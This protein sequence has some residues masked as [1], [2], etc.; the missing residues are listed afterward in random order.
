MAKQKPH[1]CIG[2]PLDGQK[3]TSDEVSDFNF[4]LYNATRNLQSYY[5]QYNSSGRDSKSESC[6]WIWYELVKLSK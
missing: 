2:G 4:G 3:K 6:V 5:S 1:L